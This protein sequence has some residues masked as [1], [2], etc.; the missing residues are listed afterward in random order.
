[1]LHAPPSLPSPLPGLL[2]CSN[3]GAGLAA[4]IA[5]L[6][7]WSALIVLVTVVIAIASGVLVGLRKGRTGRQVVIHLAWAA[8]FLVLL[9]FVAGAV[10][11]VQLVYAGWNIA[12]TT[13]VYD[14]WMAPLRQPVAGELDRAFGAVMNADGADTPDRRTYLIAALPEDLE[15][16]DFML[17]ERERDALVAVA[18]QL[19]TENVERKLGS[20]V[21]NLDRL[22]ALVAWLVARPDLAA[23]LRACAGGRECTQEV[24]GAAERWCFR[25][26][27][28][29]RAAMTPERIADA[30]ALFH[31][32]EEDNLNRVKG[33][34][35]HAESGG[36]R[37]ANVK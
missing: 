25:H 5:Q 30:S 20:H 29:C 33:I 9:P 27:D 24:L 31:R 37:S 11:S 3:E 35:R 2:A 7:Y 14:A 10:I 15:K 21:S 19:R 4:G 6:L 23:A 34:R 28:A 13:K 16:I 1:M 18:K 22:D 12:R 36:A 8:G 32:S 17:N 26:A